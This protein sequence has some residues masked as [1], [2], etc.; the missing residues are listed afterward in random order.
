M[1]PWGT[2]ARLYQKPLRCLKISSELLVN[3]YSQIKKIS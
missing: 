2:P 3:D 1:D